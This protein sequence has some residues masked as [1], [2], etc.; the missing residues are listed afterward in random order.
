MPPT[1]L[2][3]LVENAIKHG[4]SPLVDGGEVIIRVIATTTTVAFTVSDTGVGADD[5][6]LTDIIGTGIGLTNTN[7]RLVKMYGT[8]LDLQHNAPRGL[9]VRFSIPLTD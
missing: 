8:G 9:V 4:I 6:D 7:E 3:P 2:Q 1:L 5:E